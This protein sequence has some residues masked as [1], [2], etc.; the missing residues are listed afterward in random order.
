M[1]KHFTKLISFLLIVIMVLS[2]S[3]CY[4][5]TY[6]STNVSDYDKVF[7]LGEWRE[8]GGL[9]LVFPTNADEGCK[10]VFSWYCEKYGFDQAYTESIAPPCVDDLNVTAFHLSVEES[11]VGSASTEL[12]VSVKYEQD[13]FEKETQRLSEIKVDR[14]VLYDEENFSLPAYVFA[15]GH[16]QT[17]QYVLVDAENLT[18]HYIHVQLF[19][20][21]ELKAVTEE[22]LPKGYVD[23]GDVE[24]QDFTIYGS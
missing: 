13:A 3:S 18:L 11:F 8:N 24:G 6:G 10:E 19:R 7:T 9:Y 4:H 5:E 2:C 1:K 16:F 21:D 20:K 15:L 17:S 23:L 22:Y 14:A 12:L